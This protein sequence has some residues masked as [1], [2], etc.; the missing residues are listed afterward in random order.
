MLHKAVKIVIITE[1]LISHSVCEVIE[2]KGA[3]GYTI[4]AAGGKGSRGKRSTPERSAVIDDFANVKIE[5]I[6]KDKPVAEDITDAL[7]R[8]FFNNYSGI[9]YIEEV[10]ILRPEKF[11]H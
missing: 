6:V 1:K 4:V 9:T 5:V 11:K 7:L 3:T 2:E 10:E 8:D